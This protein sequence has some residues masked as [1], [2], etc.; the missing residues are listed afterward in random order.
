MRRRF[1]LCESSL[2]ARAM[3][4]PGVGKCVLVCKQRVGVSSLKFTVLCFLPAR[5]A[6]CSNA[7]NVASKRPAGTPTPTNQ[8]RVP[9]SARSANWSHSTA[10]PMSTAR[11]TAPPWTSFQNSPRTRPCPR[12]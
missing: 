11:P 2:C 8:C 4:T 10:S 12:V 9:S 7:S 1:V 3:F 5:Q 6:G